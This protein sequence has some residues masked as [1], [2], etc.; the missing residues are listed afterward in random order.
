MKIAIEP[1]C[2]LHNAA[3]NDTVIPARTWRGTTSGG[4]EIEVYVLAIA[5]VSEADTAQLQ[6]EFP[7]FLL[8]SLVLK[9][10]R[11]WPKKP[12]RRQWIDQTASPPRSV[13]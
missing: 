7:P 11:D 12:R 10:I 2:E 1:T 4:V 5:P 3:I 6:E 9:R 13:T 8:H